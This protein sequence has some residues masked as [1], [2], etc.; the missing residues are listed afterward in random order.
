MASEVS[1][2]RVVLFRLRFLLANQRGLDGRQHFADVLRVRVLPL[3]HLHNVIAELAL[4]NLDVADL[5]RED[6]VVELRHH[7][8]VLRKAQFAARVLAARVVGVLLG[9]VGPVAAGLQLL[10]NVLS[11]G[12]GRRVGLGIRARIHLDQDVPRP[13]LL[14]RLYSLWCALK[15]C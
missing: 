10:Q 2:L 13:R 5:L 7:R 3:L 12:L 6:R 14:R 11:L 1:A 4:H 9:Q 15:Y 8:P